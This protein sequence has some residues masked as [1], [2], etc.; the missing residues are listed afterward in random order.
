MHFVE[1][2]TAS[3]LHSSVHLGCCNS[4]SPVSLHFSQKL[5]TFAGEVHSRHVYK[6][7][8]REAFQQV[9]VSLVY[10]RDI[11]GQLTVQIARQS[12]LKN[13]ARPGP[14]IGT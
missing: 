9:R 8:I 12:Q 14:S 1:I 6:N 4:T 3:C 7:H 10:V 5:S 2:R 13:I 11:L